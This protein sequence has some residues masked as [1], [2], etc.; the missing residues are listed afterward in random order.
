MVCVIFCVV[1]L[2]L[3]AASGYLQTNG[4]RSVCSYF[5]PRS[6]SRAAPAKSER[7]E[8]M[9]AC[10]SPNGASERVLYRTPGY[11]SRSRVVAKVLKHILSIYMFFI[12]MI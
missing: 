10:V 1:F 3:R 9:S 8:C 12:F 7:K 5:N 6:G 11:Q 2:C 4:V